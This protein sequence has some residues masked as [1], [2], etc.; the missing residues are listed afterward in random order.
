MALKKLQMILPA[1][2][3]EKYVP[4]KIAIKSENAIIVCNQLFDLISFAK[5]FVANIRFLPMSIS[6]R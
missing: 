1:I 5:G 2:F 4:N 3:G 6:D